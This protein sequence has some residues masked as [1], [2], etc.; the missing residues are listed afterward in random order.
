MELTLK[1]IKYF[2]TTAETGQISKAADACNVTQSSVTIAVRGLEDMLGYKLFVRQSKGMHL[3]SMGEQFLRHCHSIL[4]HVEDATDLGHEDASVVSGSIRVG[5]TESISAYFLPPLWRKLKTIYPDISIEVVEL[6]RKDIETSLLDGSIDFSIMLV[7]NLF[8]TKPFHVEELISSPRRLWISS[9]HPLVE[10]EHVSIHDLASEGYILLTMD[11][12][13]ATIRRVWE[14]Y[15]FTPNIVFTS[16][17]MEA[18]RSMVANEMG[19]AIISDMVY[20][21]WSLEGRRIVRKDLIEDMPSM[22]TGIAWTKGKTLSAAAN[23][24]ISFL[25]SETLAYRVP[26]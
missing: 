10:K 21:S 14:R 19:V 22:N 9:R 18:L 6:H 16:Y 1:Q 4:Q 24:F 7:S 20:R 23:T 17:S 8:N 15:D 3:T 13:E 5:V 26:R 11:E 2:V 12:H 25:R